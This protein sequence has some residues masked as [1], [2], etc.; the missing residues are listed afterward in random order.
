MIKI[1]ISF[2][3][4]VIIILGCFSTASGVFDY[5]L[6][7]LASAGVGGG[8][9]ATLKGAKA[10]MGN[11]AGLDDPGILEIRFWGSQLYGLKDLQRGTLGATFN[12]KYGNLGLALTL[13]GKTDYYQETTL[14]LL[15]SRPV[16][17]KVQLGLRTNYYHLS[18][19]SDYG[20]ASS[21]G[22]D[23]GARWK[24]HHLV[25]LGITA[26]NLSQSK[27]GEDYIPTFLCLGVGLYPAD[28]II[29]NVDVELEDG[30]PGS[31]KVGEELKI[32]EHFLFRTG[33]SGNP[34]KFHFGAGFS[35]ANADIEM[36]YTIHPD[37]GGSLLVNLG[38]RFQK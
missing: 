26:N 28:W 10:L 37:L 2:T 38:Y 4:L 33:L 9:V 36:A 5:H 27:V 23:L 12:S 35:W 13:F 30:F 6:S 19:P 34:V 32:G 20:S 16:I 21:I 8:G 31:I 1:W 11:P 24:P 17:Y 15:Y 29:F 7:E 18:L 25:A 14:S 3:A 22:L